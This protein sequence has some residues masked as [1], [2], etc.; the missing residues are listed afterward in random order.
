M[1]F[2]ETKVAL[3][4]LLGYPVRTPIDR[5][6]IL[7]VFDEPKKHK[8]KDGPNDGNGKSTTPAATRDFSVIPDFTMSPGQTSHPNTAR[9][10]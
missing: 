4:R 1:K 2:D 8:P 6:L 9:E 5:K 7:G 3:N 10:S